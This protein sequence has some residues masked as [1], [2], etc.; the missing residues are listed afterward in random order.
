M[1]QG[2]KGPRGWKLINSGNAEHPQN[3]YR[4]GKE[5]VSECGGK[6][7]IVVVFFS[8]TAKHS[9]S[10]SPLQT[11][12][13]RPASRAGTLGCSVQP[14]R[15]ER[16]IGSENDFHPSNSQTAFRPLPLRLDGHLDMSL[17]PPV[18]SPSLAGLPTFLPPSIS[19]PSSPL[20]TTQFDLSLLQKVR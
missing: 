16:V 3:C 18:L 12:W 15:Y 9:T 7:I 10:T 14:H 19:I 6:I 13:R 5:I 1:Q 8:R 2:E 20:V 11:K 4:E 17:E